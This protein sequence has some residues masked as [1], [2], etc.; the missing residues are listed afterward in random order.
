MEGNLK[1]Q[2]DTIMR[3]FKRNLKSVQVK[4]DFN[5]IGELEV[6][7]D[8]LGE[9]VANC[10][11]HR[12][13]CYGA[14][15]RIFIFDDRIEIHSPGTLPGDLSVDDVRNGVSMP[16][17][18]FLFQ[19]AI[20]MLPYT[21]AGSGIT[22]VLEKC[23]DAKFE[24]D[25]SKYEFIVTIPRKSNHQEGTND[26]KGNHQE[27]ESNHQSNH[28]SP[29]SIYRDL[30]KKQIDIVNFCTVP[31]SSQEIMDRLGITNQSKNRAHHIQPLIDLGVLEMTIPDNPKSKDQKYRKKQ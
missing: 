22:R 17:N 21:G 26:Q 13:M 19:N 4:P 11:V 8:A 23:P 24:N 28:E 10:L 9:L 3:F 6:S 14:P 18:S 27:V 30:T 5:T 16:R 20:L 15:I 12:S 31:R 7:P 1:H 29:K 25:E 2:F